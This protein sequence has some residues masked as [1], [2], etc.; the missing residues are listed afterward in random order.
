MA[1]EAPTPAQMKEFYAQVD[2]GL[3]DKKRL[4]EFLRGEAKSKKQLSGFALAR[5]ILGEDFLGPEEITAAHG[6]TY[7]SEYVESLKNK[8]PKK[9]FLVTLHK[10][11]FILIAGPETA[12]SA[13]DLCHKN[14]ELF[15]GET[16]Q[17]VG[18]QNIGLHNP[19]TPQKVNP[20][21]LALRKGP[22]PG[23]FD[24]AW[25]ELKY[26]H[27]NYLNEY[28]PDEEYAPTIAQAIWGFGTYKIL[29][30][31]LCIP[32]DVCLRTSSII[33]LPPNALQQTNIC[34][35]CIRARE[36]D[37]GL[38]NLYTVDVNSS[39]CHGLNVAFLSAFAFK[40]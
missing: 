9:S 35:I 26:F 30:K 27:V 19:E 24:T 15:I 7:S 2:K 14:P 33:Y 17:R 28:V 25:N 36:H 3:I 6:F 16:A 20:G 5:E 31:S 23:S 37:G 40:V 1:S 22:V 10:N 29:R 12:L 38:L 39:G 13:Q 18:A 32:F 11:G 34:N 4:Q 8:I 21:W